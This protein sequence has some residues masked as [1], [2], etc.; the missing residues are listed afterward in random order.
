MAKR[1]EERYAS[2]LAYSFLTVHLLQ[3]SAPVM[4]DLVEAACGTQNPLVRLSSQVR[5]DVARQQDGLGAG[6]SAA[7][8][9]PSRQAP[10]T[11]HMG[12]LLQEMRSVD[13]GTVRGYEEA[14][15]QAM[16][17]R[18]RNHITGSTSNVLLR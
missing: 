9:G 6:M 14:I 10:G 12:T 5:C 1:R 16:R 17:N 18:R 2:R 11:F 8:S 7:G 15:L 13:P 3:A 4:R